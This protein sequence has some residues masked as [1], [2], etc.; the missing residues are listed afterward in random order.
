MAR[1]ILLITFILYFMP[2]HSATA[3]VQDMGQYTCESLISK[4]DD[5]VYAMFWL[6]GYMSAQSSSLIMDDDK[7]VALTEYYLHYCQQNPSKSIMDGI[8]GAPSQ[9]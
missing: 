2:M 7:L 3:K 9:K 5:I 6:H 4:P 8:K 1:I